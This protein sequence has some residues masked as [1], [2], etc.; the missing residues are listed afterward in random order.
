MAVPPEIRLCITHKM[1][2]GLVRIRR[3][4]YTIVL[5]VS[6]IYGL[7]WPAG[8]YPFVVFIEYPAGIVV[9]YAPVLQLTIRN[10]ILTI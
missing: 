1:C 10:P 8:R 3:T 2:A 4:F 6:A 9:E 5:L 7:L